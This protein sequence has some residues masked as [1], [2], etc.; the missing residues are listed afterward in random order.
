MTDILG[1]H[2]SVRINRVL[3]EDYSSQKECECSSFHSSTFDNGVHRWHWLSA[4]SDCK[5]Y[6]Y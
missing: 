6:E 2:L 3:P 5:V 1:I 4:L